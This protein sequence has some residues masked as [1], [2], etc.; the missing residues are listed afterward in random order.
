M[1]QS[2]IN[3]DRINVQCLYLHVV[4]DYR[5]DYIYIKQSEQHITFNIA[6]GFDCKIFVGFLYS[7]PI[8]NETADVDQLYS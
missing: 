6:N 5:H 4:I 7:K 1:P 8:T 2:L 3:I